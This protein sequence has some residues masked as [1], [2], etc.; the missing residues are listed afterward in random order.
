MKRFCNEDGQVLVM[1]VLCMGILIGALGM[2]VDVGVLFRA[3]RN[4]Q[5]AAD[6]AAMAGA[7]AL[8][9]GGNATTAATNAASTVDAGITSSMVTVSLPSSVGGVTCGTCVQVN[10]YKPTATIFM[11]TF[12]NMFGGDNFG[13]VNVAAKS[14][15][16][17]PST[18]LA[19]GYIM[20]P[21]ADQALWIHGAGA[22]IAPGC[23][24]YVNSSAGDAL[25]V[26]G[27]SGKSNFAWVDVVGQQ[28]S[29]NCGGTIN[30]SH[31]GKSEFPRASRPVLESG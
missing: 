24:M 5:I 31:P 26:T 15:A 30:S 29:G 19:C 12:S 16:G 25:C 2:A 17:A 11:H 28:G 7:T 3:R 18:G 14:I 8:Y 10:L 9:Y 27:K 6:S 23:G 22:I 20:S 4:M 1:T 13:L 21:T